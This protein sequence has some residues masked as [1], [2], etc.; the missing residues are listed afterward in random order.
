MNTMQLPTSNDIAPKTAD[1]Q[2]AAKGTPNN[3]IPNVATKAHGHA[4]AKSPNNVNDF[5]KYSHELAMWKRA[6]RVVKPSHNDNLSIKKK[7]KQ[8]FEDLL[9]SCF[10]KAKAVDSSNVENTNA[11]VATL[12]DIYRLAKLAR[13]SPEEKA[14]REAAFQAKEIRSTA[15][16]TNRFTPI[17]KLIFGK[18]HPRANIS[19]YANTLQFARSKKIKSA[20]FPAFVQEHN[21]TVACAKAEAE[22]RRA[23]AGTAELAEAAA[24]RLIKERLASAP[25]ISLPKE[26][27]IGKEGLV[28]LLIKPRADGSYLVLGQRLIANNAVRSFSQIVINSVKKVVLKRS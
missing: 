11:V 17:V 18:E 4:E 25:K 23:E 6:F 7:G 2:L 27:G 19:R 28:A 3:G 5:D 14:A 26:L 15:K 10:A 13:K 12:S 9:Q 24:A 20:E 1:N 16:T 8:G 22:R 21:G